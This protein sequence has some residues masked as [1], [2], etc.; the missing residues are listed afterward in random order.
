MTNDA[1]RLLV[2]CPNGQL[3]HTGCTNPTKAS[4]NVPRWLYAPTSTRAPSF[5]VTPVSRPAE[6]DSI[7]QR[8]L[9]F[10]LTKLQSIQRST[11]CERTSRCPNTVW[12][13]TMTL[14]WERVREG[15][16]QEREHWKRHDVWQ[17]KNCSY[18]ALWV[19]W[20]R[21]VDTYVDHCFLLK[22]TR[23][24]APVGRALRFTSPTSLQFIMPSWIFSLLSTHSCRW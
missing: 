7:L 10:H 11:R 23:M 21:P 16:R 1:E 20:L 12:W 8:N 2:T 22:L 4:P 24:Y 3:P 15:R 9:W 17:E 18:L 14:Q 13:G 5:H 6:S 19:L